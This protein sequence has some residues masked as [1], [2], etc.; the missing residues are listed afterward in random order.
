M[1]K[2]IAIIM[3]L[4]SIHASAQK[5]PSPAEELKALQE[6]YTIVDS[7][8]RSA[9]SKAVENLNAGKQKLGETT[10]GFMFDSTVYSKVGIYIGTLSTHKFQI[11]ADGKMWFKPGYFCTCPE[12]KTYG[13]K[14]LQQ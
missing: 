8:Y 7:L 11:T 9:I 4:F 1:K 12:N 13:W 14:L 5:K 2:I 10:G 3:V 6:S